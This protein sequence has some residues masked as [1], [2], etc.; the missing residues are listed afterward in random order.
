MSKPTKDELYEL[1][2]G[3]DYSIAQIEQ[4]YRRAHSTIRW[5][6]AEY[7]IPRRG[8]QSVFNM[9]RWIEQMTTVAVGLR[10]RIYEHYWVQGRSQNETAEQ[11]PV[12]TTTVQN[13]MENFGIP[14]RGQKESYSGEG[15]PPTFQWST[16]DEEDESKGTMPDDPNPDKYL[17][18]SS[19]SKEK[20]Y[21]MYWGY[22][23]STRQIQARLDTD[24]SPSRVGDIIREMGIPT[25][26]RGHP[27]R[28]W[29][30]VDGVPPG[31]EWPEDD[32]TE[33]EK[34]Y[35]GGTWRLRE[36]SSL[37]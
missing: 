25:R 12:S 30:P 33:P 22:G 14:R 17:T 32:R 11:L 35:N 15:I 18:G 10:R 26:P 4:E 31:Y 13:W 3:R 29:C 5:Y 36:A 24:L 19:F 7:G 28:V 16:D 21:Q 37:P 23:F 34:D 8:Q 2:W 20:L 9:G 6:F 1:Y 27:T